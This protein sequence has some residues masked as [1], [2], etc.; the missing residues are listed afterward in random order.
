MKIKK[1]DLTPL[2]RLFPVGWPWGNTLMYGGTVLGLSALAALCIF[3]NRYGR[4]LDALYEWDQWRE[5]RV[6]IRDALMVPFP[7]ALGPAL[8]ALG[9]A[10]LCCVLLPILPAGEPQRLPDAPAAPA[11]G[12][13]P[14]VPGGARPAAGLHP[15]G[16]A[17]PVR[18]VFPVV[19]DGHPGGALP[20]GHLG[21]DGRSR[22]CWNVKRY[23]RPISPGP[24][25][26]TRW[27]CRWARGR[28]W[29]CSGRTARAR[30]P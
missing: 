22:I 19:S 27:T 3:A 1:P 14:A 10:A 23:K 13:G 29:A 9:P 28:S 25:P 18:S 21:H 6:L 11:V 7:E 17:A 2:A 16:G 8:L 26:W 20:A 15:A 30:P 12:A 4:A 5:E 24:R